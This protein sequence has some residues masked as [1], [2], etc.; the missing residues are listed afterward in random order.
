MTSIA[1]PPDPAYAL[2]GQ[3]TV[4]LARKAIGAGLIHRILL[5]PGETVVEWFDAFPAAF[6]FEHGCGYRF[7]APALGCDFVNNSQL[8][9]L[10]A[11][12]D[13]VAKGLKGERS[14]P[15]R[16]GNANFGPAGLALSSFLAALGHSAGTSALTSI[17]GF[18]M[19]L[20]VNAPFILA[21]TSSALHTTL[22]S[23]G[24]AAAIALSLILLRPD[25][26]PR[27][28]RQ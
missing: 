22:L 25:V 28:L 15:F 20:P 27:L 26:A 17:L 16:R 1:N 23:G 11:A 3:V 7:V 12:P 19:A 13:Y 10:Y 4:P 2:K 8:V 18:E 14:G 9:Y 5:V 21:L 6:P 24:W